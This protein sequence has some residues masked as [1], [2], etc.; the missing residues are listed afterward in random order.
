VKTLSYSDARKQLADTM[1]QV[2]DDRAPV[3]ITRQKAR[4]VVMIS[5]D[6]YNSLEETA[7]LLRSPA[8]AQRLLASIRQAENGKLRARKLA[9]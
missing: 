2:C 8:N 1:D 4:P 3:I 6:D 9:E 5:L 7:Y